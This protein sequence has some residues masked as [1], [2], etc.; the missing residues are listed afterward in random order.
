M[1][2]ISDNESSKELKTSVAQVQVDYQTKWNC[3]WWP[4]FLNMKVLI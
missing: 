2:I 1:V 4:M 3:T